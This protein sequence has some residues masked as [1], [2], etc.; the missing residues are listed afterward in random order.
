[1]LS[2]CAAVSLGGDACC[3]CSTD[4]ARAGIQ[5][6]SS[7]SGLRFGHVWV[8]LALCLERGAASGSSLSAA[9]GGV[10]NHS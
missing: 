10:K 9:S 5:I 2:R 3:A 4:A 7:F 8:G 1:M 6:E